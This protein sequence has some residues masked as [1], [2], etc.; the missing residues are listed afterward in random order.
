MAG[1]RTTARA[2]RHRLAFFVTALVVLALV[3]TLPFSVKSVVDDV[4]GPATGRVMPI[5]PRTSGPPDPNH[6]K[7]HLAVIAIDEVQLLAT[8]RVSGH[9]RCSGCAWKNRVL[10]V[11]LSADDADADGLPPS[12][13][14]TLAPNDIEISETVQLP[15]RGHPIH[16]PFD[17]YHLGL[18]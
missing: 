5:T 16:Y 2:V 9:H 1:G 3:V 6:T 11:A 17:R 13:S 15:M 10:L 8:I 12:A 14:V 7:L 4:L 18:G